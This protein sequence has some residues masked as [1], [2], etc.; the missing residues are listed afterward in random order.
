MSDVKPKEPRTQKS[1][2]LSL[3][4][5]GLRFMWEDNE[6]VTVIHKFNVDFPG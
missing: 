4:P 3:H 5:T 6:I 1:D 2:M